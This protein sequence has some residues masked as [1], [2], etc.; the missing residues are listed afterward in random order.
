MSS[1]APVVSLCSGSYSSCGRSRSVRWNSMF[2]RS[3]SNS[4]L[5][6][7]EEVSSEHRLWRTVPLHHRFVVTHSLIT[8]SFCLLCKYGVLNIYKSPGQCIS[9]SLVCNG[10]QDCEDGLDE[11]NCAPEDRQNICDIDKTPPNSELTGRGWECDVGTEPTAPRSFL[12]SSSSMK[13]LLCFST[14]MTCWQV[15]WEQVWSTHLVLEV[16]AGRPSVE[17]IRFTTV[18]LTTSSGTTSRWVHVTDVHVEQVF[19]E[20]GFSDGFISDCWWDCCCDLSSQVTVDNEETDESYESSWSYMQHIQS[21]ALFGHDRRTFHKEVAEN[22]VCL[23]AKESYQLFSQQGEPF[24]DYEN[25]S[26]WAV[27]H[28]NVMCVFDGVPLDQ[29]YNVAVPCWPTL[30]LHPECLSSGEKITWNLLPELRT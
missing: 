12:F 20:S 25:L 6:F 21:N 5:R 4:S 30:V 3:Y 29:K 22:K 28:S 23:W 19:L 24:L 27:M 1:H 13:F 8:V 16:S 7:P 26:L 9:Q 17:T 14:V 10:D 11:R 18:C 15:N 2:R